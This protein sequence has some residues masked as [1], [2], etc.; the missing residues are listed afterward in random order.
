L[1]T[2]RRA[3]ASAGHPKIL[4]LIIKYN[5]SFIIMCMKNVIGHE[6]VYQYQPKYNEDLEKKN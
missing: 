3:A 4:K 1:P 5:H 2:A 6:S